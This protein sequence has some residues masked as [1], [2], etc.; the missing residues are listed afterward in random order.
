[1]VGILPLQGKEP[2]IQ[3]KTKQIY[4]H[5]IVERFSAQLFLKMDPIVTDNLNV[6]LQT[7][8]LEMLGLTL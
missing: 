2:Y 1:M 8:K 6:N 5:M 4:E 7:N 3:L